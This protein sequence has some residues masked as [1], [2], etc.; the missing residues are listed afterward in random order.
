MRLIANIS[1]LSEQNIIFYHCTWNCQEISQQT[2]DA[3]R[4]IP[5]KSIC[6]EIKY[7]FAVSIFANSSPDKI[8]PI[9]KKI[10]HPQ[11]GTLYFKIGCIISFLL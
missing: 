9:K 11:N 2:N 8:K 6:Y 4:K 7:H 1:P 5:C 3:N 10:K